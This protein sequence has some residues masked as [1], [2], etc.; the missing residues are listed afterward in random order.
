MVKIT[1]ILQTP[2]FK[3]T[4]KKLH[5]NQK[6]DLD[7]A[8]K[9]LIDDPLI[10]DQKKGELIFLRVYTFKMVKQWTLLAYSYVDGMILFALIALGPHENFYRDVKALL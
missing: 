8:I 5:K 7:R 6:A 2:S 10:G 1:T 9:T 3:K 4:V